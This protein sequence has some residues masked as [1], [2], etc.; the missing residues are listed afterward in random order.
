MRNR[1]GSQVQ[2]FKLIFTMN[3][4]DPESDYKALQISSGDKM[5]TITSGG[6]NTLSFYY[7]TPWKFTLLILI[8]A[9]LFFL[10]LKLLQ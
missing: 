5:M 7:M 9:S 10:S 6:C 8:Q 2:L 3:W 4:E 1:P